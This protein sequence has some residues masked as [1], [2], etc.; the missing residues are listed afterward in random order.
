MPPQPQQ[1]REQFIEGLFDLKKHDNIFSDKEA[2]EKLIAGIQKGVDAIK[3]SYGA[4]GSNAIIESDLL[5]Y[6]LISNDGKTILDSIKLADPVEN[7]GLNILKEV[8]KKTDAESGDGRKTSIILTGAILAEGLKH[9]GSPMELKRSLDECLPIILKSLDDQTKEITVKE[10]GKIAEIASESKE[11]GVIYGNIYETIGKDGIVEIDNSGM[12]DTFFTVTEGVRLIGCGFNYSY[13]ANEDKGRK[14]VYKFPKVLITK[15]K[16][17]NIY[18]LDKILKSV[19]E[20]GINELVIFC[21]E[22]DVSVSQAL[23]F[24][25]NGMTPDGRSVPPFKTLVIKAPTLWKDWLFEDFAK[26][27]GAT[28]IESAQGRTLKSFRYD[29]LGYCD[30]IV[31]SKDETIVLGTQDISEHIQKLEEENTDDS[32]IR[33]ARLKTKTAIL[34]LGANSESELSYLRGK[35]LDGR[36]AAYLALNGGV[37]SGGGIA[38]MNSSWE[39]PVKD[40]KTKNTI[41]HTVGAE[42]LQKALAYPHKQILENSG[43]TGVESG[44]QDPAKVVKTAIT[45]ALS[46]ASTILTTRTVIVKPK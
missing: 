44:I 4:A 27:T 14:A 24:L 39:L 42:I 7:I 43:K 6:H 11:L 38:L 25:H 13:M 20:K 2:R 31:A 32:K 45:N 18:D 33:I 21:D 46:V 35:A 22:I 12:S 19:S 3:V 16:I 17:S 36:N 23:A 1:T 5:P 9:K 29:D 28:I 37:V 8:A 30:K 34:K 15:Q 10:V 40:G 41:E 26:I